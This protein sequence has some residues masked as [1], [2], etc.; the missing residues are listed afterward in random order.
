MKRQLAFLIPFLLFTTAIFPMGGKPVHDIPLKA[1][2]VKVQDGEYLRLANYIRGEK[3]GE[4][5]I[6]TRIDRNKNILLP[7]F[8]RTLAR[9][10][11]GRWNTVVT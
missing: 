10:R 7:H 8:A 6:V 2:Q 9:N 3:I 1:S 11:T 4:T 5:Y